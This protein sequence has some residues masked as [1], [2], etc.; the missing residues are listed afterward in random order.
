MTERAAAAIPTYYLTYEDLKRGSESV[1]LEMFQFLLD[2]PSLEGTV[3]E[4][5]IK[6]ICSDGFAS[7][8]VYKLKSTSTNLSRNA[9]MYNDQQI[10]MIKS[11]LRDHLYY[12]GYTNDPDATVQNDTAFFNFDEHREEDKKKF[13][14]YLEHNKRTLATLG[15]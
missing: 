11:E 2:V 7:K 5:N 13:K 1:V 9:H 15:T 4:A 14:G 12:F 8:S 3:A 6:S 10:D